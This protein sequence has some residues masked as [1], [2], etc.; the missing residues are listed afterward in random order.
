[1]RLESIY[2]DLSLPRENRI[3]RVISVIFQR[4]SNEEKVYQEPIPL[5]RFILFISQITCGG[6][7]INVLL[8][9][10]FLS[11]K[12]GVTTIAMRSQ[13]LGLTIYLVIFI[14]FSRIYCIV[15]RQEFGE[16]GN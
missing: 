7:D 5:I 2:I 3:S 4:W 6:K 11:R 10:E 9:V 12:T 1:M 15:D 13:H 16:L 8:Q 14:N